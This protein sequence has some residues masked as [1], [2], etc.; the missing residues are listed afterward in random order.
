MQQST[1]LLMYNYLTVKVHNGL[2]SASL[3]LLRRLVAMI[4]ALHY[5]AMLTNNND[6]A[7][8]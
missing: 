7:A 3:V 2:Y 5:K 8:I 4:D 1:L 6:T